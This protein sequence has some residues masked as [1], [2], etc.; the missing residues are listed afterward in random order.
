LD[1]DSSKMYVWGK[2]AR[3]I[4]R[5]KDGWWHSD[6]IG[7]GQGLCKQRKEV[8]KSLFLGKIQ[9]GSGSQWGERGAP[10]RPIKS[11]I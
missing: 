2:G 10:C 1:Q 9:P 7:G 11:K 4:A 6:K 8:A 3:K 5:E